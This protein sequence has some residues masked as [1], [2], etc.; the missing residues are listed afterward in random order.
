MITSNTQ[1]VLEN[2]DLPE[3][4][5]AVVDIIQHIVARYPQV[6]NSHFRVSGHLLG[7]SNT[8][9]SVGSTGFEI[10]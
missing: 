10:L 7:D 5:V 8:E 9:L 1:G 2:A 4:L 6:F 3:L